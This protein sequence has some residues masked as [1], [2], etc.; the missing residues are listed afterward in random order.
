MKLRNGNVDDLALDVA[1]AH[2]IATTETL[3]QCQM[4]LSGS[5]GVRHDFI[6]AEAAIDAAIGIAFG[7][8]AAQ[9]PV[10]RRLRT[11]RELLLL[12][13]LSTS[14]VD[15]PDCAQPTSLAADG[16]V[17]AGLDFEREAPVLG[18]AHGLDL[19]AALDPATRSTAGAP[20]PHLPPARTAQRHPEEA[21]A[22]SSES[23]AM[24]RP[25]MRV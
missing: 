13:G 17:L 10:L 16:P 14:G 6:A 15:V 21:A 7:A 24:R 4:S 12:A 22:P 20:G 18:H 9:A 3:Q 2:V 19:A 25:W 23:L 8:G 5:T 11:R 1:I